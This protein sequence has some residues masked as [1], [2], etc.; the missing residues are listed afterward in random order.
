MALREKTMTK[1]PTRE[2]QHIKNILT[3]DFYIDKNEEYILT[4]LKENV[5][6]I[7]RVHEQKEL[8]D[9]EPNLDHFNHSD[10]EELQKFWC[11]NKINQP[12]V[13]EIVDSTHKWT[14]VFL[15]EDIEYFSNQNT[16]VK[17]QDKQKKKIYLITGINEQGNNV[18][19]RRE[20]YF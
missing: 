17:R 4:N 9:K 19:I 1:H 10:K 3:T 15:W 12:I 5:N 16:Y 7:K 14:C 2:K 20:L 11:R 13:N 6:L 8:N 18:I